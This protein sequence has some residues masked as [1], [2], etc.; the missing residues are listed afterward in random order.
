VL[1]AL[2]QQQLLRPSCYNSW[3][4]FLGQQ[5]RPIAVLL[6]QLMMQMPQQQKW[7]Q[8]ML[9]IATDQTVQWLQTQRVADQEGQPPPPP[10]QPQAT[11]AGPTGAQLQQRLHRNLVGKQQGSGWLSLTPPHLLLLFVPRGP[12]L[13]LACQRARQ[14]AAAG[15]M[16][17]RCSSCCRSGR[18]MCCSSR[19]ASTDSHTTVVNLL[20]VGL[21]MYLRAIASKA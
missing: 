5:L 11:A 10:Q 15:L 17:K 6:L 2:S 14:T 3:S 7:W 12:G 9:T 16:H 13:L 19:H 20:V 21:F 4:Q 8:Q 18:G 1:L